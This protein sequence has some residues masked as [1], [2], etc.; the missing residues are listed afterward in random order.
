MLH[1]STPACIPLCARH[2]ASIGLTSKWW[3]T[4]VACLGA[5]QRRLHC[6]AQ[7]CYSPL[8]GINLFS[9]LLFKS[10]FAAC[11]LWHFC[12]GHII[13][14]QSVGWC[15]Y[16]SPANPLHL[17]YRK[18]HKRLY[19]A[20]PFLSTSYWQ[21][22]RKGNLSGWACLF[23]GQIGCS[24]CSLYLQGELSLLHNFKGFPFGFVL[25]CVEIWLKKEKNV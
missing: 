4:Y 11:S 10:T 6:G 14:T 13:L 3:I 18:H 5:L 1:R 25:H 9:L 7:P 19:L 23:E 12:F 16:S 2:K 21:T 20:L 22:W 24:A 17:C 15:M 8:F